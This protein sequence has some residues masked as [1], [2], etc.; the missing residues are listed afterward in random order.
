MFSLTLSLGGESVVVTTPAP[1]EVNFERVLALSEQ[2][3]QAATAPAAARRGGSA[4]TLFQY[5]DEDGDV[6][7]VSSQRDLQECF[8]VMDVHTTG[9]LRLEVCLDDQ[10]G[11]TSS[12]RV[13]AEVDSDG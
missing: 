10:H 1:E 9:L 5:R 2:L 12:S 3:V 4:S 11:A 7:T 8:L 13:T 6:V